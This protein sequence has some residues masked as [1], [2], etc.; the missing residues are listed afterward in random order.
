MIFLKIGD[1]LSL[2]KMEKWP[3]LW[4]LWYNEATLKSTLNPALI[5]ANWAIAQPFEIIPRGWEES[6]DISY[7]NRS[8]VAGNTRRPQG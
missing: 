5:K 6:P 1:D 4:R 2:T 7:E 8:R 3:I